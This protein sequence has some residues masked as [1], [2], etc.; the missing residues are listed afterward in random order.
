VRLPTAWCY[1][2]WADAPPVVARRANEAATTFGA[3]NNPAKLNGDVLGAWA[4]ILAALP[5]SR[6]LLHA[7]DDEGFRARIAGVFAGAG[8]DV[9][10]LAFFPRLATAAYLARY[11]EVD[12][13][14]D[15]FPC[16]GAT[17]TLDALWMGVPVVSLAG[18]RPYGRS[19][20]SILGSL[21]LDDW[22]SGT[23]DAYVRCAID[24]ARDAA[25]LDALRAGLRERLRASALMDGSALARALESAFASMGEEHGLARGA[26]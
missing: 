20:A 8:V 5:G 16:A 26:S 4:R 10:R 2:P 14:L 23:A 24:H 17:T 18:D 15:A 22:V 13:A 6:I 3:M 1:R 12:I 19:G 9:S 7:P 21:G 11:G 25:A